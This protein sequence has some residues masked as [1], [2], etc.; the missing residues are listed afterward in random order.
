M[1]QNSVC[2][3]F[4]SFLYLSEIHVVK[5][6]FIRCR[7]FISLSQHCYRNYSILYIENL[8][9]T[10]KKFEKYGKFRENME[11]SEEC[12]GISRN[13]GESQRNL[14]IF[15]K[16]GGN[17]RNFGKVLR[18][19]QGNFKKLEN[20]SGKIQRNSGKSGE[21]LKK[22]GKRQENLEKSEKF[23]KVGESR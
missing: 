23:R 22:F 7:Q 15:D 12:R 6:E 1:D 19:L 11:N 17:S 5:Q 8:E 13:F 3:F 9:E 18:N 20:I 14:R 10:L 4:K 16:V 2:F 21:T